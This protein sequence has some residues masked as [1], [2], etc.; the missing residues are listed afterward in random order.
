MAYYKTTMPG[1]KPGV[2]LK[3]KLRAR[4]KT[5]ELKL[6]RV[7]KGLTLKEMSRRLGTSIRAVWSI[8]EGVHKD[9]QAAARFRKALDQ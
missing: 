3:L 1:R 6:M 7:Q 5:P 4:T 8:E 9:P 2:P